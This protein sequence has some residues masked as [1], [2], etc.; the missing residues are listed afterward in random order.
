M[1]LFM[2]LAP[3]ITS[4]T[5]ETKPF[6]SW[7]SQLSQEGKTTE[8]F[9][10]QINWFGLYMYLIQCIRFSLWKFSVWTRL[11]D[12][13]QHWISITFILKFVQLRISK[14]LLQH[15]LKL[16]IVIRIYM[17][18]GGLYTCI[19][20]WVLINLITWGVSSTSNSPDRY[21]RSNSAFSPTYDEIMRFI[22]RNKKPYQISKI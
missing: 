13:I 4:L 8:P 9:Q 16:R 1:L 20:E 17:R 22:C 14:D 2:H 3:H 7:N 5:P 11:N 6:H 10:I 15:N 21:C 12:L 19:H 18:I